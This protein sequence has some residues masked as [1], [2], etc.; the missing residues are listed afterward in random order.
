MPCHIS[1][2]AECWENRAS[3]RPAQATPQI[4]I[5]IMSKGL[6]RPGAHNYHPLIRI[7]P[8]TLYVTHTR[9]HTYTQVTIGMTTWQY[10]RQYAHTV[11]ARANVCKATRHIIQKMANVKE[12]KHAHKLDRHA[13]GHPVG[14]RGR[15]PSG[16]K[17][18]TL[19]HP[20]R[21]TPP[22]PPDPCHTQS[23]SQS[24]THILQ[25]SLSVSN[26]AHN[27]CISPTHRYTHTLRHGGCPAPPLDPVGH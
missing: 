8:A 25:V 21:P 7:T 20:Y 6:T 12:Y 18:H 27:I 1:W 17:A 23:A 5:M 22:Y 13:N 4:L 10:D 14:L 26:T 2:E 3:V 15:F 11:Y 16:Q 24:N 9:T 19:H